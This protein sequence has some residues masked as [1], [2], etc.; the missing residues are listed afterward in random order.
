MIACEDA[1]QANK[2]AQVRQRLERL[3]HVI[4]IDPAGVDNALSLDDLRE[5]GTGGA[6]RDELE[7]RC[8]A[9]SPED[10]YTVIYTSGTIPPSRTWRSQP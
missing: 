4:V 1:F 6:G 10:P 7:R 8:E 3:E 9:V 5:R 2:I